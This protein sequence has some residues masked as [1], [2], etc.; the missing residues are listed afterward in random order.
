MIGRN[1]SSPARAILTCRGGLV[2]DLEWKLIGV[3]LR[4]ASSNI[5]KW[6]NTVNLYA[7]LK[8]LSAARNMSLDFGGNETTSVSYWRKRACL[9]SVN[10]E[11]I[12]FGS[13]SGQNWHVASFDDDTVQPVHA[14]SRNQKAA[15]G[16]LFCSNTILY[17]LNLYFML[18]CW[19]FFARERNYFSCF[20]LARAE[21]WWCLD[22]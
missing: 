7:K 14:P 16:E 22:V 17:C 9:Y 19:L 4:Y 15:Q 11:F 20:Q 21:N 10:T 6:G 1:G 2:T 3:V 12:W 5:A 18:F 13:E 8:G